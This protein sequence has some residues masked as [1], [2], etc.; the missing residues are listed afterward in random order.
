MIGIGLGLILAY[1]FFTGEVGAGPGGEFAFSIPW[2][3]LALIV[4]IAYVMSMLTTYLPS[5]QA[6]RVYP[7]EALR[8]E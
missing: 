1:N 2:R 5:W 6:A 7:A 8:Y 4:V 3:T